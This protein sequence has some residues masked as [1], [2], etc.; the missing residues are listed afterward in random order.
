MLRQTAIDEATLLATTV[1]LQTAFFAGKALALAPL[2]AEKGNPNA[3]S[4]AFVGGLLL[5]VALEGALANVRINL[6]GVA[7]KKLRRGFRE[8]AEELEKKAAL[9]L[10]DVREIAH[11][12]T[13]AM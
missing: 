12:R 9:S 8:D 3:S 13:I 6:G 4:D 5:S 2:I 7:D 11:A 10:R 1:P